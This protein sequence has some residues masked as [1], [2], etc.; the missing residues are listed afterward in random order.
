MRSRFEPISLSFGRAAHAPTVHARSRSRR[1]TRIYRGCRSRPLRFFFRRAERQIRSPEEEPERTPVRPRL[2][3]R[4][5]RRPALQLQHHRRRLR[6]H[7]ACSVTRR[8]PQHRPHS[9]S[10]TGIA[11]KRSHPH[12]SRTHP[13]DS[14]VGLLAP[15]VVLGPAREPA[16]APRVERRIRSL[17]PGACLPFRS[18]QKRPDWAPTTDRL[19]RVPRQFRKQCNGVRQ[20]PAETPH[21]RRTPGHRHRHASWRA[22]HPAARPAPRNRRNHRPRRP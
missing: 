7:G 8:G 16:Q 4:N 19:D 12:G 2:S 13:G 18:R 15:C 9:A 3:D 11:C 14:P 10:A 1:R 22:R 21:S 17:L 6:S 20:P 5:R